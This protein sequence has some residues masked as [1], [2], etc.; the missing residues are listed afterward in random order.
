MMF[1]SSVLLCFVMHPLQLSTKN[2][3][4]V[5]Y[6]ITTCLDPWSSSMDFMDDLAAIMRNT[7]LNA[8]GTVSINDHANIT[9][10]SKR[11]K[12]SLRSSRFISEDAGGME[13]EKDYVFLLTL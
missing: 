12:N 6:I 1:A 3:D 8:I 5:K 11:T 2:K 4:G 13:L 10:R 9:S 7:V